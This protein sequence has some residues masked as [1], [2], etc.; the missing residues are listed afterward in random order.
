MSGKIITVH[1]DLFNFSS[2]NKTKKEKP[3]LKEIKMKNNKTI[4]NAKKHILQELRRRQEENINHLFQSKPLDKSNASTD[5]ITPNNDFEQSI[6]DDY[7][8]ANKNFNNINDELKSKPDDFQDKVIKILD[9]ITF[10]YNLT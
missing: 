1:P 5:S 2:K 7:Q 4:K 6:E 3:P 9:N 10:L 8:S